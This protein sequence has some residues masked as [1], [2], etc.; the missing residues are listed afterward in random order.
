MIKELGSAQFSSDYYTDE[1]TLL[2]FGIVTQSDLNTS[3]TYLWGMESSSFPLLSMTEGNM[4]TMSKKPLNGAD[5]QYKYRIMGR[6][7]ETSQIISLRTTPVDG[8][9]GAYGAPISVEMADNFIPYQYGVLLPDGTLLRAQNEGRPSGTGSY[10]YTFASQSGNGVDAS[11]FASG[12][13]VGIATPTIG[14]SKSDGNR[15]NERGFNWA[16]NQY[17]FHRFSKNIAGNPDNK[18]LNVQLDIKDESG[19]ITRTNKWMPYSM[20]LWEIERKKLLEYDL[21]YSEYNRNKNGKIGLIDKHS[22]EPIPKG[23]GVFQQISAAGNDFT[24]STFSR[25]LLD[26]IH[27]QVN[28]NRIGYSIGEKIL[29]CGKG[30]AREFSKALMRESKFNSY[31]QPLG[32]KVIGGEGNHLT[33]GAYFNQYKLQDGTIFTIKE[34]DMFDN[35]VMAKLQIKNGDMIGGLPRES[36]TAVCLDHSLV[37]G[38]DFGDTR[39]IQ[40]VYE[41][42]RD[43]QYGI[44]K[45][46]AVLPAVW[47]A[48]ASNI[49][50]DREDKASYEV[51]TSQGINILNVTTSFSL[52]LVA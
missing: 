2:K 20:K 39:N 36:Y 31:F 41:E 24:Y 40:L 38:E 7:K 35:G 27:D 17:S 5:T 12:T 26:R 22:N 49:I 8:L 18:V 19:K 52:R 10:I 37:S 42:G 3:L 32:D 21:W 34:T 28:A 29:Y 4:A 6:E 46:M 33:Y 51:I 44:Y 45:G 1:N 23:A 16:T 25:G 15:S 13:Y 47:Q 11:Q 9:V 48:S 50:S 43:F 14:A 30:F